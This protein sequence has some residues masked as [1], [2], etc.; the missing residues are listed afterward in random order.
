[1]N[2][3]WRWWQRS[4]FAFPFSIHLKLGLS[5][6]GGDR[7]SHLDECGAAEPCA[8]TPGIYPCQ[9]GEALGSQCFTTVVSWAGKLGA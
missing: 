7:R 3:I 9:L 6:K 8:N 2:L 5:P 4:A 1:M